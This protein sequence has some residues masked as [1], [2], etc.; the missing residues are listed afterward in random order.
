MYHHICPR[1]NIPPLDEQA[2]IEGWSYNLEPQYFEFQLKL[3]LKRGFEFISMDEYVKRCK[4]DRLKWGTVSLTFDDG[5]LDNYQY[6]YPILDDLGITAT[7]FVVSGAV[8]QVS[9]RRRMSDAQIREL[10]ENGMTIGAHSRT[11]QDLVGLSDSSLLSE[12]KGCKDDLEQ[13]LGRTVEYFAYPGGSFNRRAADTVASAGFSA[14]CSVIGGGLNGNHNLFWLYRDVF[15]AQMSCLRDRIFLS[16]F[17]RKL[18]NN[19]ARTTA[20]AAL[21]KQ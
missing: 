18:L 19:R 8:A 10:T 4:E 1:E 12:I 17:A 2:D 11:H 16:G 21:S 3:L 7:F 5:W 9:H 15:S 14:S 13:L 6:A 20:K